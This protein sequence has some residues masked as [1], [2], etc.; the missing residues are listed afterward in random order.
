MCGLRGETIFGPSWDCTCKFND[1]IAFQAFDPRLGCL[2]TCQQHTYQTKDMFAVNVTF[3]LNSL[4]GR[5]SPASKRGLIFEDMIAAKNL[6]SQQ[7]LKSGNCG[8]SELLQLIK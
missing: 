5:H 7:G 4:F 6:S 1:T 3:I 8:S 2:R